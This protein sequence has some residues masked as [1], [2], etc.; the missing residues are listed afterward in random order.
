MHFILFI[1]AL[2]IVFR[3]GLYSVSDKLYQAS[4]IDVFYTNVELIL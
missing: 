1:F 2:D 3:T 4:M